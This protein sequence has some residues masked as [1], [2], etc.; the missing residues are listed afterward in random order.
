VHLNKEDIKLVKIVAAGMKA[1][2]SNLTSV[3]VLDILYKDLQSGQRSLPTSFN[4]LAPF[5]KNI[6]A[7]TFSMLAGNATHAE[8]TLAPLVKAFK[9][10]RGLEFTEENA[11]N[12]LI[13]TKLD[14]TKALPAM[15]RALPK[16]NTQMQERRESVEA[17]RDAIMTKDS[18]FYVE[19]MTSQIWNELFT[20]EL[21]LVY[22]ISARLYALTDEFDPAFD[23]GIV[24]Y[25]GTQMYEIAKEQVLTQNFDGDKYPLLKTLSELRNKYP[26]MIPDQAPH[27]V[28]LPWKAT[29]S[30]NAS[31][32]PLS[33]GRI[34]DNNPTLTQGLIGAAVLIAFAG[35]IGCVIYK[36]PLRG[37]RYTAGKIFTLF[38][39]K[40]ETYIPVPAAA[41]N[42]A[43]VNDPHSDDEENDNVGCLSRW[44]YRRSTT[45]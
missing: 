25:N 18:Q 16:L 11:T 38:G 30:P 1:T 12:W 14:Y 37:V 21:E 6:P 34:F 35:L 19:E 31:I 15:E 45:K 27:Q 43:A 4:Y 24:K 9:T 5:K 33:M 2:N 26:P 17:A 28:K 36:G 41:N 22:K 3:E 23:L 29:N 44:V 7:D 20:P 39:N 8:T 10:L 13:S 42:V 32:I 40:D